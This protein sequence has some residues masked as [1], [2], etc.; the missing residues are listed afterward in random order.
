MEVIGY[1]SE[2]LNSAS[3]PP[4]ALGGHA[5][6]L[7][8]DDLVLL[9][10]WLGDDDPLLKD[11]WLQDDDPAHYDYWPADDDPEAAAAEQAAWL[12]SLP[13]DIRAAYEAGPYT[14]AG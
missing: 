7:V 3:A 5:A 4:Q 9:D 10:S 11:P 6:T 14:G 2:N 8:D 12:A 1:M 13:E